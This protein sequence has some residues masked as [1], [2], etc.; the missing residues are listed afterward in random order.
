M[1]MAVIAG[2]MGD[3]R[4]CY[5]SIRKIA[6]YAG[7]SERNVR[8][9]LAEMCWSDERS[10]VMRQQ[11]YSE[12]EIETAAAQC[13]LLI[14]RSYTPRGDFT[15]NWYYLRRYPKEPAEM[16]NANGTGKRRSRSTT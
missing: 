11:G 13:E 9:H 10:N 14:E 1:L 16:P 6:A 15:S 12:A 3:D 5:P 4:L 2:Y 7:I 8:K